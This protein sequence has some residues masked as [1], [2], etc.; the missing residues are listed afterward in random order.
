[1]IPDVAKRSRKYSYKLF[2]WPFQR[3]PRQIC[4]RDGVFEWPRVST[5]FHNIRRPPWVTVT[6]AHG[7]P[8]L[9]Q[10]GPR[11][12]SKLLSN[13]T[14]IPHRKTFIGEKRRNDNKK[15]EQKEDNDI[16]FYVQEPH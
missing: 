10:A 1:M 7:A 15:D 4:S 16:Q 8:I 11:D 3:Y 5:P 2:P 12:T 14:Y 6:F 9:S 13:S